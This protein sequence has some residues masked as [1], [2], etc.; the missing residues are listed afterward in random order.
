MPNLPSSKRLASEQNDLEPSAT[1]HC[2]RTLGPTS[3]FSAPRRSSVL[4]AA[5]CAACSGGEEPGR[6]LGT[7]ERD[8]LELVAEAPEPIVEIP[9]DEGDAV[10]AGTL[11]VRLSDE[12]ARLEL[13][14][15]GSILSQRAAQAEEAVA[16]P[17]SERLV[18]A[19]A[20]LE[21]A[22][23]DVET[24][25]LD[26]E[27]ERSLLAS[28]VVAEQAV[29]HAE[30]LYE[31]AAAR[32]DQARAELA[33]LVEG[34]RSEQIRAAIQAEA[35]ARAELAAAELAARRLEVRAPAAGVVDALPFE[36]GERPPAGA[37]VA[38]MLRA[39]PPWARVFVP[40]PRR[41][42]VAIGD[43][44]LV[45]VDGAGEEERA[46]RGR[47]RRVRAEATFTP[48]E[49]LTEHDRGRLAYEAE[50][51]LVG[52][53]A[54]ALPTGLPVEVELAAGAEIEAGAS[55]LEGDG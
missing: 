10:E 23:S 31:S 29:D 26:L 3:W 8:R 19:R 9:V 45:F 5:V 6:L 11:L 49:S 51:E 48:Y 17:R 27:R 7:L 15:L 20:R 33:E 47:V 38:V 37:V 12:R 50:V 24:A 30:N 53:D 13:E 25:R 40:Q 44:A 41:A 46:Y 43:P 2:S 52:E 16:G 36:V 28:G 22:L 18:E 32:V 34:T 39:G 21:G 1:N 35:A 14:R 54:R 42:S 55:P 4:V